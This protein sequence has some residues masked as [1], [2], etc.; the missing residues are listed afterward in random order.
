MKTVMALKSM[1][2]FVILAS[3]ISQGLAQISPSIS[4]T[5]SYY[6]DDKASIIKC[7]KSLYHSRSCYRDLVDVAR[8]RKVRISILPTCCKAAESIDSGCW[9]KMFP[10]D[11][12][13]PQILQSLCSGFPSTSPPSNPQVPIAPVVQG[14][15][16]GDAPTP[17]GEGPVADAPVVQGS[18]SP[19]SDADAPSPVDVKGLLKDTTSD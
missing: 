9:P 19:P 2:V 16:T 5:H 11:P 4:P 1:V 18:T 6:V 12:F 7:W 17:N 3:L 15:V 13:F 8:R 10:Y 14:P